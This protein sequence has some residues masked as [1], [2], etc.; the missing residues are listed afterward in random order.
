MV[1]AGA[2][3]AVVGAPIAEG[4]GS[5]GQTCC[6]IVGVGADWSTAI[7]PSCVADAGDVVDA[8]SGAIDAR[9]LRTYATPATITTSSK[10]AAPRTIP[11]ELGASGASSR[12][13]TMH[14]PSGPVA[15]P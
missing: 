14:R 11:R 7:A 1:R 6:G 10:A 9:G 3:G 2:G 5:G 4:T 12:R 8:T 15:S 13:Q